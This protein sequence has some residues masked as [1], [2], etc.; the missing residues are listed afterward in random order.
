MINPK[1]EHLLQLKD[2]LDGLCLR[3][4]KSD[5]LEDLIRDLIVGNYDLLVQYQ[6]LEN[7]QFAAPSEQAFDWLNKIPF[8]IRQISRS[9]FD[10]VLLT[11]VQ[12]GNWDQVHTV[13]MVSN[14]NKY[15]VTPGLLRKLLKA[16][17][18]P[19][20]EEIRIGLTLV[21]LQLSIGVTDL[22]AERLERL[23]NINEKPHLVLVLI[24]LY[25][26]SDPL[27]SLRMLNSLDQH[28]PDMPSSGIR[29]LFQ[30]LLKQTIINHF[31]LFLN[32]KKQSE[33]AATSFVRWSNKIRSLWVLELIQDVISLNAIKSIKKCILQYYPEFLDGLNN[34]VE[35]CNELLTSEIKYASVEEYRKVKYDKKYKDAEL[36]KEDELK[37]LYTSFN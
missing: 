19:P 11:A 2:S 8:Y 1:Y 29:F 7:D 22:E 23:I 20:E 18:I 34:S 5:E 3:M 14:A 25:S 27:R 13:L 32:S 21:N 31:D 15:G 33:D 17:G 28:M 30:N 12:E 9:V 26:K 35:E 4:T 16:E 37:K 36:S 6:Y 10:E 24:N